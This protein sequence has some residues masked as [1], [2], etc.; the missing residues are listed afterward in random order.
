[1]LFKP[2]AEE[3]RIKL[4]YQFSSESINIWGDKDKISEI[5]N[6]LI[7]N[8]LKFTDKGLIKITIDEKENELL[9]SVTD[10]GIGIDPEDI[11]KLFSKYHQYEFLIFP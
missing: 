7:A 1:M 4:T 2:Q 3:K 9:C 5:F 6:N 10:T 11:P 8:A